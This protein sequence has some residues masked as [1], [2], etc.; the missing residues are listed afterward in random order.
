MSGGQLH[1]ERGGD[2]VL[3]VTLDNP[4]HRNALND[5]LIA[6]LTAALREAATDPACRAVV[7]RGANGMFCAG[8]ELNDVV[9]LQAADAETEAVEA[10]YQAVWELNEALYYLP[11]PSI[12]VV[13]R[14][15]LGAG[16]GLVNW[17][18]FA[19]AEEGALFG[20]P[21]VKIGFP[22]TLTTVSLIRSIGRKAAMDLLLT[23]R[24]ITAEEALRIGLL[25][26]VVPRGEAGAALAETLQ[27][28]LAASP[29]AIART[30]R[31]VWKVEDAEYR[32]ACATAVDSIS[33]AVTTREAREGVA[34]FVGKRPPRW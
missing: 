6:G 8:R 1:V 2:G 23:G 33:I 20:Y 4:A 9:R 17:T 34:A 11:K 27:L 16:A 14:F 18:D 26:R 19:I 22:P 21:E 24:N 15:A 30:K 5:H 32:A 3:T 28:L 7:L 25:T 29:D 13:E 12:A 10:A 31:V